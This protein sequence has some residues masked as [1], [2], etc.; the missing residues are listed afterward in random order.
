MREKRDTP[1]KVE[2]E[3]YLSKHGVEQALTKCINDVVRAKI[4]FPLDFIA[5][6]L[7]ELTAEAAGQRPAVFFVL[8]GPG[9]G[10]GTQCA[11]IVEHF[12]Y[13]H[14]SA[15]DLL[16]EERSSGSEQGQMIV[17]YLREGKIVHPDVDSGAPSHG[18]SAACIG[19]LST[20]QWGWP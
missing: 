19:W 2:A 20:R 5:D 18:L 11:K 12:G 17:E 1:S 6:R 15:G 10:K 4:A 8:G 14:L 3:A 13:R 16:R 7:K 9:A